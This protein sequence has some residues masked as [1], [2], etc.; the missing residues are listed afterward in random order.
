M[1]GSV[2]DTSVFAAL[3]FQEPRAEEAGDLLDGVDLFEPPLLAYELSSVCRKKI[4]QHPERSTVLLRALEVGLAIHIHWVDIDYRSVVD[5]SLERDLST[6]DATFLW[7]A[8]TLG[9]PLH[10][11]DQ[12]LAASAR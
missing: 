8:N 11:F 1:P 6:Y 12:V 2:A 9:I 10:T 5:L 4:I 7:V 3:V